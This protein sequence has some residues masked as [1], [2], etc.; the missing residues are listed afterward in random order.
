METPTQFALSTE[1]RDGARIVAVK[2]EL[3]L[4]THEQLSEQLVSEA[5][6]GEPVIVDLSSCE[7]ID[8]SGI[9]ALLMG[10]KAGERGGFAVAGPGPQVLR[11]LEMTGLDRELTVHDSVDAALASFA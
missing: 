9:R 5:G 4:S 6:S 11:I 8:S 1:A 7:F 2:G 3:D 10:M